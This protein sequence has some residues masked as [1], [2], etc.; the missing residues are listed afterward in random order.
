M[1]LFLF[2]SDEKRLQILLE[3]NILNGKTLMD[4]RVVLILLLSLCVCMFVC[5]CGGDGRG[6][7]SYASVTLLK[8]SPLE[9]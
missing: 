9:N 1:S 4:E 8:L 7:G 6:F 3:F 5:V 2:C